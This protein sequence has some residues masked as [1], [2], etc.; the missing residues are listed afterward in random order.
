MDRCWLTEEGTGSS[1][2]HT[3][4]RPDKTGAGEPVHN[5]IAHTVEP[6]E[7]VT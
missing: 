3:C 1:H 5:L 7:L 6:P 2:F 4:E